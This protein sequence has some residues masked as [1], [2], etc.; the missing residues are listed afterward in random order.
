MSTI[1][2]DIQRRTDFYNRPDAAK[3]LCKE[4]IR[5]TRQV[6]SALMLAGGSTAE[7]SVIDSL[8]FN[9]MNNVIFALHPQHVNIRDKANGMIIASIRR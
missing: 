8:S 5:K 6:M 3:F 1:E 9:C 2:E 7:D 4:G